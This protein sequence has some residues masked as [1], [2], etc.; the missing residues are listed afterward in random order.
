[1]H[2]VRILASELSGDYLGHVL[3]LLDSCSA[4]VR[5]LVKQS[6]LQAGK[7]LEE[8]LPSIMEVM[9]EVIVEKSV[10]VSNISN[11]NSC[12]HAHSCMLRLSN[13]DSLLTMSINAHLTLIFHFLCLFS[14]F[15][16][17]FLRNHWN[18]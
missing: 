2:D 6:I 18:V 16:F 15:F 7:S 9:I 8:L 10:E 12:V 13:S 5:D 17:P 1:M 14:L 11:C 3:Q 4:E